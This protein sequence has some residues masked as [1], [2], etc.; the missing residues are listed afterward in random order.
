MALL[1]T[2]YSEQQEEVAVYLA[3]HQ[4]LYEH[5]RASDSF[6]MVDV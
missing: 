1:P 3:Q 6:A 5:D 4:E 2:K